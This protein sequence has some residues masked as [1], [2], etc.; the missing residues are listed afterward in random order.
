M[1]F[2]VRVLKFL[3]HRV[4]GREEQGIKTVQEIGPAGTPLNAVIKQ[5][6]VP[7]VHLASPITSIRGERY[8][9]SIVGRAFCAYRWRALLKLRAAPKTAM[10]R[11]RRFHQ[12]A[13]WLARWSERPPHSENRS[14]DG[15]EIDYR[16]FSQIRSVVSPGTNRP[17]APVASSFGSAPPTISRRIF[18][19]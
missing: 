14:C 4:G 18:S 19:I 3:C 13:V 11:S 10:Y 17:S 2:Q 12:L 1:F 8:V 6:N 9:T 5:L 15:Y 7:L 16:I